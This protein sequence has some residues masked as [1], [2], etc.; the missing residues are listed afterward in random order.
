MKNTTMD[1]YQFLDS[2][3]NKRI[4]IT[5]KNATYS[6]IV[7]RINLN[8]TVLLGDVAFSSSSRL[9]HGVKDDY[10]YRTEGQLT[11]AKFQPYRKSIKLDDEDDDDGGCLDFVVIDEFYEKF[12][13]AV[14]HIRKQQVI[15]IGADGFG[16]SQHERLCWLQ[17]A[18]KTKVYLFDILQ[19]GAR[20]FKNGLSMILESSHMLKVIHDCRGIAGCLWTQY[21]V[22]LYNIFDTQV[23]DVMHF[24]TET[25]GFLPDRVSTL[26]EVVGC[27][28]KMSPS[29]LAPLDIKTQLSKEDREVWC[30]RP[31]PMS[32]LKMM[33]QSVIHLQSLRLALLDALMSDYMNR[34]DSYLSLSREE[35][36]NTQHIGMGSGLELPAEL[37]EL[38]SLRQERRAWAAAQYPATEDGLLLRSSPRSMASTGQTS[39]DIA[40]QGEIHCS[41]PKETEHNASTIRLQSSANGPSDVTPMK[42]DPNLLVPLSIGPAGSSGLRQNPAKVA[43]AEAPVSVVNGSRHLEIVVDGTGVIGRGRQ[44]Q[45]EGVPTHATCPPAGRGLCLQIPPYVSTQLPGPARPLSAGQATEVSQGPAPHFPVDPGAPPLGQGLTRQVAPIGT[46]SNNIIS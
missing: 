39:K 20:A 35:P 12:G 10:E 43:S 8:K 41:A 14:M 40:M 18:T 33:S 42:T 16:V 23:A 27:H 30:V 1:D 4:Q 28:L 13:P 34:V 32:L 26:Q 2:F 21:G 9:E 44:L 38:E 15:G 37:R 6:G 7:Q 36:V 22:K 11:V 46:M 31:C 24:Y 5:L 17:I 45:M 19:L 3:K 29:R 25:G